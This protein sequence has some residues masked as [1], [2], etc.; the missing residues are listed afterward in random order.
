MD[1]AEIMAFS[2]KEV[3][4]ATRE[5]LE[6]AG[7][8]FG[9]IDLFVLHQANK[10]MLEALGKKMKIP[11]EKLPVVV[12]DYGNTVSSTIPLT[13]EHLLADDTL[14]RGMTLAL[15]GFGVGY[16]W[17]GCILEF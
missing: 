13:L 5:L 15:V 3:P 6:K 1:G 14:K 9:Q 2:L 17:A 12:R 4:S 11:T 7:K 16:S 10:F 8:D